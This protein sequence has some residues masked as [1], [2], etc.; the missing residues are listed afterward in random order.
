MKIVVIGGTGLIGLKTVALLKTQGH[1]VVAASPA[2]GINAVT[3]EGLD[4]ALKG[5][6]VVLDLANSPSFEDDAVMA[7]FKTAGTNLLYA[8]Q[9]AGVRHH[10]ALSVVGT[11]NLQDSGYFRAK[12]AQEDL[13]KAGN[14][15]FTII[16]STQFFEFLGSIAGS[17]FD[18]EAVRLSNARVQPITSQDVAAAV[19]R[20]ALAAPTNGTVEIAGPQQF[21]LCDL[22]ERYLAHTGDVRPV[23]CD[24]HARYFGVVLSE[25][26]LVP[27]TGASLGPTTFEK[28]LGQSVLAKS[29]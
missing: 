26:S 27:G 4:A 5:A 15:P 7:F 12:Q 14:I 18:G 3:G 20:V 19:A 24:A 6:E 16:Q 25:Y 23:I 1:N 10:V 17:A 13:I 28:W 29:A 11:K 22:V 8:E 2:T 9:A 21:G